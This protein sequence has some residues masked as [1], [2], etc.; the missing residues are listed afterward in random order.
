MRTVTGTYLTVEQYNEYF[1]DVSAM[2]F[3]FYD[4][5]EFSD[6]VIILGSYLKK[7]VPEFRIQYPGKRIII[8]QLEQLVGNQTWW[9]TDACIRNLNGADAIWDYDILNI[10]YMRLYYGI[11]GVEFK[12]FRYTKA[13]NRNFSLD[14]D[15]D[16]DVLFYGTMN[17]RRY[18][19]ISKIQNTFYDRI[20]LVTINGIGGVK[21]DEYISRSKIIL[22]IHAFEPYNR[23]EQVRMF[24]N[25]INKRCVIS[26]TTQVNHMG[27]SIIECNI[28]NLCSI[29]S[30]IIDE[31]LYDE[32]GTK[33]AAIYESDTYS[34]SAYELYRQKLAELGR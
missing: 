34:V 10:K 7:T 32:I 27:S 14:I 13:L 12:P 23:Q 29:I 6:A 11:S 21:L 3:E 30:N 19:W 20:S 18:K 28:D 2:L 8:Y 33:A 16:I 25:V 22:N 15:R 24:Y 4:T 31:N 1:S 9:S 26:E 5:S 17:D